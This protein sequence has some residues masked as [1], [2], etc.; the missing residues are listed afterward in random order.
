MNKYSFRINSNNDPE[1]NEILSAMQGKERTEFI[2]KALRF[3]V[4]NGELISQILS[5][6]Q[7]IQEIIKQQSADIS[8]IKEMIKSQSVNINLSKNTVFQDPDKNSK[9]KNNEEILKGLVND[10]LNM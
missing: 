6:L 8:E 7:K 1:I 10:F 3:Y 5:D 2:R 9:K 4:K